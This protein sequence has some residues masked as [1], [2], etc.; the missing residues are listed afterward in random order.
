MAAHAAAL[1]EKIFAQIQLV[2]ALGHPIVCMTHLATG[3]SVLLVKQR[4]QPERIQTVALLD[5]GRRSP[6]ATVAG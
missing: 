6:I 5:A 4:M 3:L 2:G 1:I